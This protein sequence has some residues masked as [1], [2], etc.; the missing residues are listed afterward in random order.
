M[1][2]V[3]CGVIKDKSNKYLI[4]QK[5]DGPSMNFWEFAGGKVNSSESLQ[6]A[7]EREIGEELGLNITAGLEIF[8]C[9]HSSNGKVYQLHFLNAELNSETIK[10]NEHQAYAWVNHHDLTNYNFVPGDIPFVSHL[11]TNSDLV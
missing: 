3:V 4:V 5:S 11:M 6:E 1:V 10:L 9:M 7:L 2:K 8:R